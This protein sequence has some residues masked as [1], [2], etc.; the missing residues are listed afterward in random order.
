MESC[1][2]TF[3]FI[4]VLLVNYFKS[5]LKDSQR[6]IQRE[7]TWPKYNSWKAVKSLLKPGTEYI[8]PTFLATV[9]CLLATPQLYEDQTYQSLHL[10]TNYNSSVSN[11]HPEMICLSFAL[12]CKD[13]RGHSEPIVST[14]AWK[15]DRGPSVISEVTRSNLEL[16]SWS[17]DFFPAQ[18]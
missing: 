9:Y 1:Q 15:T 17:Q 2:K 18:R 11:V 4:Q 13:S 8:K 14:E 7:R 5:H 3:I 10:T 12:V 6:E 16:E